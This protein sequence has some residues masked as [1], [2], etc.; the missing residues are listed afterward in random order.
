MFKVKGFGSR[1]LASRKLVF[2]TALPPYTSSV[3]SI[4]PFITGTLG[5]AP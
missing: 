5:T 2:A 1:S 4:D 3:C